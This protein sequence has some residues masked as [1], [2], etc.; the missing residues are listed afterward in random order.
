MSIGLDL[1]CT[2]FRSLRYHGDRLLSRSC[3][4]V[5]LVLDDIPKYRRI[6]DRDQARYAIGDRQI[7]VLGDAA[8]TWSRLFSQPITPLLP[9]GLLPQ[10]DLLSRQI[11]S[12]LFDAV[13]PASRHP[14]ELCTVTIPGELLPV[15]QSPE[16][17]F[18]L[19]LVRLRGYEP[20]VIG[21]GHAIALAE[22]NPQGFSGMGINLGAS[23]SEFSL[24]RS[25]RELARCVIP[26]GFNELCGSSLI[27]EDP[28]EPALSKI[29]VGTIT[30]FL[31]ELLLEAGSRIGQHDGF[32]V[33]T[34]PVSLAV[35]GGL[36]E[37]PHFEASFHRA[38]GRASWP[39]RIQGI[40]LGMEGRRTAARGC[41]IHAIWQSQPMADDL[42]VAA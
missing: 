34:H 29:P 30:D 3:P 26:Y 28:D 39:I 42:A 27:A 23:Q 9:D 17:D 33:L 18:F 35:A 16:R 14:R 19:H 8:L 5:M 10:D 1:G 22:L 32:R 13:L 6:L 38:W 21:Q 20:Q 24:N 7:F 4:A 15:E 37:L 25:G 31:V 12:V 41:L 2:E 36:T 40:K 11:L